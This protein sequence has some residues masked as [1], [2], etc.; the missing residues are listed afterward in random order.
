MSQN[1]EDVSTH[2]AV[3]GSARPVS[4]GAQAVGAADPDQTINVTV[5]V[6]RR[7]AL[8]DVVPGKVLSH[9]EVAQQYGAAPEDL[10]RVASALEAYGLTVVSKDP[11]ARTVCVSGP[12]SAVEAAFDTR[13]LDYEGPRGRYRGRRGELHVPASI[14]DLVEGVFGL[15][16][17][18]VVKPR[19]TI[20]TP[21][22]A[23]QEQGAFS[24]DFAKAYHF[25][26]GTGKGQT[27]ALLEFGGGYFP[28]DLAAYC[29]QAGIAVPKVE[30]ISVSAPTDQK[31]GAE[32][33][34][35]LDV[36]VV[37][38][39]VPDATIK[40]Y[41]ATF[42]EQGWV[43]VLD[44]VVKD[45]PDVVSISWGLA[46]DDAD[47]TASGRAAID[48]ALKQ[49]ALV[50]ITVCVASG[51]DGSGDQET[52]GH[53]H[54]DFPAASPNVL[55]VGGT[56]ATLS[57]ATLTGET[58]WFEGNGT[59]PNGGSGG[60][61]VSVEFAR[62]S[63]QTVKVK[64][65][66]PHPIDGRVVPDLAAIAGAPFYRTVVDGEAGLVGGTSAAA[67]LVASLILRLK[68]N[69]P[70]GKKLPFL[71]PLLYQGAG[72]AGCNDIATGKNSTAKVGGYKAA[73]GYDACT[74]W[75]SPNGTA[76]LAAVEK[77]L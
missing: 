28:S 70:S 42:S 11:A 34:V 50:G 77:L 21:L 55:A 4:P 39:V 37:A 38:A 56:Q 6:R 30:A 26:A 45:A 64:S 27:I 18:S 10:D 16:T 15:D 52:D 48:D 9:A 23:T 60:G 5:K 69:L 68:A 31:D 14:Q 19:G 2:V 1:S 17:R 41:F 12:T 20:F 67:P 40:V 53:A 61:G 8:P 51:D 24:S 76:L 74:G 57:G 59:R 13:L 66:N 46:E 43:D 54:S 33:E 44:R 72:A 49:A 63:W 32:G 65:V 35:M 36:E 75:G 47:W 29:T 7:E 25:P 58:V 62:P 22:R 71:A 3:S 73:K